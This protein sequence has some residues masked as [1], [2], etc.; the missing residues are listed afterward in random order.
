MVDV[1]PVRPTGPRPGAAAPEKEIAEIIEQSQRQRPDRRDQ[2]RSPQAASH[3][4]LRRDQY[5][6]SG[7]RGATG[8]LREVLEK[9]GYN[10]PSAPPGQDR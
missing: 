7:G 10:A 6:R 5:R 2:S 1:A 8:D 3:L 4:S 9:R